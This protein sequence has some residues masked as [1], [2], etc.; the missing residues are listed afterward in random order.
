MTRLYVTRASPVAWRTRIHV[1]TLKQNV[2]NSYFHLHLPVT[3]ILIFF[4]KLYKTPFKFSREKLFSSYIYFYLPQR[5]FDLI[6]YK[7]VRVKTE[8]LH[9]NVHDCVS[10]SL[11]F[12]STASISE[13]AMCEQNRLI[14]SAHKKN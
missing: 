9:C 1:N 12:N 14:C 7:Y 5:F 8:L 3:W 11:L 2:I 6:G 13:A 10:C 4:T